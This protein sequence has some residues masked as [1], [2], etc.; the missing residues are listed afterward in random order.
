[1]SDC[2]RKKAKYDI[3]HAP[4][5]ANI[6]HVLLLLN[7]CAGYALIMV[8]VML[9]LIIP[10]VTLINVWTQRYVSHC[11]KGVRSSRVLQLVVVLPSGAQS[12][13]LSSK[14]PH[15]PQIN[16]LLSRYRH[17]HA[18]VLSCH[19]PCSFILIERETPAWLTRARL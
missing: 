13:M 8:V 5:P 1:M 10:L 11:C 9:L 14:V 3:C 18:T 6:I 7:I 2:Q 16:L 12:L 19:V 17:M 4:A 15:C